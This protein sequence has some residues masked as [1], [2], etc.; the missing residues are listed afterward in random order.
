MSD[1]NDFFVL[2][3]VFLP[4]LFLCIKSLIFKN[5]YHLY[6]YNPGIQYSVIKLSPVSP[7]TLL[8]YLQ[9]RIITG[10]SVAGF[11]GPFS[12]KMF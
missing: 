6:N 10:F 11:S 8:L 5:P 9:S 1:N 2:D 4:A 12:P 3:K 7:E